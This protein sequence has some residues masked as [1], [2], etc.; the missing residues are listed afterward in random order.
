MGR[1]ATMNADGTGEEPLDAVDAGC[2]EL[3]GVHKRGR[4]GYANG[5]FRRFHHP[6]D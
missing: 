3:G 4:D 6:L 5:G 1:S 2:W